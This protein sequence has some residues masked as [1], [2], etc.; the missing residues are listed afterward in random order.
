VVYE[1]LTYLFYIF[2]I[3]IV[4]SIWKLENIT[5]KIFD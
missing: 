1:L 3:F 4:V 5:N 2:D